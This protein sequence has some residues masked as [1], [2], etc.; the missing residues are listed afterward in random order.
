MWG[1]QRAWGG[2]S[3]NLVPKDWISMAIKLCGPTWF[4]VAGDIPFYFYH[5]NYLDSW[6]QWTGDFRIEEPMNHDKL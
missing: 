4:Q 1:G 3:L 2:P 5:K 6:N